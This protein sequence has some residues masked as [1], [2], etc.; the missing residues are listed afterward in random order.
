MTYS[1][2]FSTRQTPQSQPIP[3]TTQ[4]PNSAGGYAW[5]VDDWVRLDRFLILGSEGGSYYTGERKLTVENAE[6]VVRCIKADGPHTVSRIVEISE[7]GR[8]P[9]NDPALFALAMCAG[10][11]DLD[12]RKAALDVLPRIAR[13]GTHLFTFLTYVKAFRGWGRG[14]REAV[15]KWYNDKEPGR[16]AYQVVK[17]RQRGGW[18]HR[19]VLRLAHPQA[20]DGEHDAIYSWLADKLTR[21]KEGNLPHM[22]PNFLALQA[23]KNEREALAVIEASPGLPWETVPTQF[24]KSPAVWEALLPRLPMTATLRNLGRMTTNGLLKPMSSAAMLVANKLTDEVALSKA[25]VH[26]LSVLLA[27]KIYEQ[28]KGLRGSL[29]WQPVSQIVDVLDEAFYLAFGNV[30]PTGKRTMLALDVSG[31]MDWNTIAGMP[32][33]PRVASAA[34]A[35]VTARVESQYWIMAFSHKLHQVSLSPRQRLDDVVKILTAIPMGGTDCS[36]PMQAAHQSS[37]E[38]DTFII[39]TDSE[40]WAGRTMHPAQA[41]AAYRQ[42]VGIP[43]KLVV[44]GMQS[45]GFSIADPN[46]AGML[47]V[48]GFDTATPNL[49][50]NFAR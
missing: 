29:R 3:G 1:Q 44:V 25:R 32:I 40:T 46:D 7:S 30:E 9:K 17:Y 19:D 20:T 35:M 26:P 27:L 49:I 41:L 21:E 2:H 28:G 6:A 12:T 23:C 48:V 15:A 31:S 33:T 14:L 45:N 36:L 4:V 24:L 18:T 11:G 22:I 5:A 34:M 37:V 42:K 16:L 8:A 39:Y 50:S 38:I 13:I 47:D 10:M 43:A